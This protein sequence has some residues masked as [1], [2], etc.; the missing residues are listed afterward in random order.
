MHPSTFCGKR[1]NIP[2]IQVR[3]GARRGRWNVEPAYYLSDEGSEHKKVGV[4][5]GHTAGRRWR[6][7]QATSLRFP[8]LYSHAISARGPCVYVQ[9]KSVIFS[10][11]FEFGFIHS[12]SPW[13]VKLTLYW[14]LY[15]DFHFIIV[16]PVEQKSHFKTHFQVKWWICKEKCVFELVGEVTRSPGCG[17]VSS[18]LSGNCRLRA[19]SPLRRSR[20]QPV[21]L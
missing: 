18:F 15:L 19:S 5:P 6:W 21:F 10:C 8:L 16:H 11:R 3:R 13:Q 1:R 12:C 4:C 7:D 20:S 2:P 14:T 17:R 9:G